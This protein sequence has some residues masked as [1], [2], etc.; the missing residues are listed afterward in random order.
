MLVKCVPDNLFIED[1]LQ[2]TDVV[3]VGSEITPLQWQALPSSH[4]AKLNTQH[5]QSADCLS[6]PSVWAPRMIAQFVPGERR[7]QHTPQQPSNIT[8]SFT[9]IFI[10]S[11]QSL[12]L[13]A[14]FALCVKISV[15][16]YIFLNDTI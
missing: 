16:N 14:I 5:H 13:D 11:N 12:S 6:T 1:R 8:I 2:N 10:I 15:E 9:F 4:M 3:H 7:L